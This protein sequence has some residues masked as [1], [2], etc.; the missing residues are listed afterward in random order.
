MRKRHLSLSLDLDNMWSYM[1]THGD[2]GWT[3]FPS[4]L[5]TVV[6]RFLELLDRFSMKITV[7]VVG[8]DAA[9]DANHA[10]LRSIAEAGHEVGNHSFRHEPWLHL[11]TQEEI[12]AEIERAAA[13]IE[14]ATGIRPRGFRGPGYSLSENVL[15]VLKAQGYAYDCST[16]PTLIGPLARS[17]Y[18]LTARLNDDQKERRNALFGHITDGLRPNAPYAW[19]LDGER[20]IEIPVTTMPYIKV[21]IHFSYIHWLA[22]RSEAIARTYF[23]AGLRL[24]SLSGIE[25]SLLLHPLDFMG[26]DDLEALAFFPGMDQNS[27]TKMSRMERLLADLAARY[28]VESMAAHAARLSRNNLPVRHP[29]FKAGATLPERMAREGATEL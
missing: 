6:P 10:A 3:A 14:V 16:F 4:Y 15:R 23:E 8:Q 22:G 9:I 18:F 11:Y 17:Y 20:L 29:D 1:K 12:A 28:D 7:F 27:A 13:A 25:P 24:C 26:G 5:D 19:N 21:P 2:P